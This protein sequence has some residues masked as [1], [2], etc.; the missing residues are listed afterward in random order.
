MEQALANQLSNILSTEHSPLQHLLDQ[1]VW[2]PNTHGGFSCSSAWEEI[3]EKTVKNHFN[4]LLGHKNIPFKS[5]FVLWRDLR[6]KFPT[7]YKLTNFGIKPSTCVCCFDRSGMDSIEHIFNTGKFAAAV[8]SCFA[9]TA[10][11]LLDCSS[12]QT[13]IQQWWAA[14]LR[15]AAHKT[16]L[17]ATPIFIC[18]NL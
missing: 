15:N 17:Q 6:G 8:W 5:S 14:R 18:W 16:L 2:N 11:M 13:L 3:R 9:A 1:A 4:Y 7:N 12:L 10:G